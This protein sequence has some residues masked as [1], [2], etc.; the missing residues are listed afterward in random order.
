MNNENPGW[1]RQEFSF[2][3]SPRIGGTLIDVNGEI[4]LFGG[5]SPSEGNLN[6]MWK[7]NQQEGWNHLSAQIV[8]TARSFMSLAYYQSQ[9]SLLLFGG[10]DNRGLVLGDTWVFDKEA[11][12]QLNLPVL[13]SP[14][15]YASMA[16]DVNRDLIVLFGGYTLGGRVSIPTGD[17]WTWNGH[18]WFQVLPAQS[19]SPRAGAGMVYDPV[20][21]MLILFGG[22]GN[23][24]FLQDTWGWDGSSWIELMPAN[25]PTAR[26]DMGMAYDVLSQR[27]ILF[28]GQTLDGFVNDTWLWDGKD[29]TRAQ[30]EVVPPL[31]GSRYPNLAYDP[32]SQKV[33][34]LSANIQKSPDGLV[35]AQAEIWVWN[36]N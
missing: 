2:L 22:V 25:R 10:V 12:L 32:V 7:L 34:F 30:P 9:Q 27:V 31:S 8:P 13:P 6:E 24:G 23:E 29:W 3:P 33:I 11:W 5:V 28:G 16:Y 15:A 35:T 20:Q 17:T 4:V 36:G 21:Q 19:P 14:R 26:A 1:E 18:E